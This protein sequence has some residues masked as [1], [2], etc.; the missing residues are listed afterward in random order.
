MMLGTCAQRG[1]SETAARQR[2]Q[3]RFVVGVD[4]QGKEND[5]VFDHWLSGHVLL[6][7]SAQH[8][9][10]RFSA[11]SVWPGVA[12]KQSGERGGGGGPSTKPTYLR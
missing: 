2:G 4:E 10:N 5:Q 9:P 11:T 1:S 3:Q 6:L 12:C 7:F 8:F